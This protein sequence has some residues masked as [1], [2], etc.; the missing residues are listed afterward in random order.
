MLGIDIIFGAING[1]NDKEALQKIIGDLENKLQT[2]DSF[3]TQIQTKSD[4]LNVMATKQM[5][6][7]I[8]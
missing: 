2:L 1:A 6:L 4:Q 3:I 5:A 7:L 8:R